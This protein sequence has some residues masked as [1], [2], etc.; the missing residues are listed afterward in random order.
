MIHGRHVTLLVRV[1]GYTLGGVLSTVG[2]ACDAI[3]F[4]ETGSPLEVV[5][6]VERL[7]ERM[8]ERQIDRTARWSISI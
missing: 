6:W 2:V 7:C 4:V 3:K 1:A 8:S 5:G